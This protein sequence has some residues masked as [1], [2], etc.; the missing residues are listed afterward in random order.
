MAPGPQDSLKEMTMSVRKK[1]PRGGNDAV[2]RMND[3]LLG[4]YNQIKAL[5]IKVER[6]DVQ[7]RYQ[8]AIHCENVC[9]GDRQGTKYG[10]RAVLRLAESLGWRKSS[11]YDYANVART[12]PDE[13]VFVAIAAKVDSFG[14]PLSWSHLT[15]LGTVAAPEWRE[16]LMDDALKHGWSVRE[17]RRR[18]QRGDADVADLPAADDPPRGAPPRL[19]AATQN[20]VT[21]VTALQETVATFGQDLIQQVRVADPADLAATKDKLERA[22]QALTESLRMVDEYL[23]VI[24]ER[25]SQQI[26]PQDDCEDP[27]ADPP[28]GAIGGDAQAQPENIPAGAA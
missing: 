28:Q 23:T 21:Q 25:C 17:L 26:R 7:A 24:E 14:K 20:Y 2:A 15:L 12:W 1:M 22:R 27:A 18:L 3:A 9:E 13:Q 5:V 19:V 4:E 16:E 11:I 6:H 10:A 8:I